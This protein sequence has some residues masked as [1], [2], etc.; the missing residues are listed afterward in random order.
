MGAS[1]RG[2]SRIVELLLRHP[3]CNPE[4][5]DRDGNTAL[6]HART[7][8]VR[9]RLHN[10]TSRSRSVDTV[11]TSDSAAT[12]RSQAAS[13]APPP[14]PARSPLPRHQST[15]TPCRHIQCPA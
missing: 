13:V 1:R 7:D 12:P 4:L 15:L 10:H 5:Q 14:A 6:H 2:H 11:P 9:W 3:D 8:S